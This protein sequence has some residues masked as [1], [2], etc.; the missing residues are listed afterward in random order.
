[1]ESNIYKDCPIYTTENLTLRLTSLKDACELLNCYSDIKAVPL[2]NCDNCHGDDFHYN[3]IELMK[4][5]I[6][7][8]QYSYKNRYFTRLTVISNET[9]EIIGTIEMFKRDAEDEFDLVGV[10]RID[11]QSKYEK[12]QYI[13]EIL[14]IVNQNFYEAFEVD[15]IITKANPT[16]TQRIASLENK[17]YVPVTKKFVYDNY[18]E[19]KNGKN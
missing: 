19:R 2:F 8:W 15:S 6:H 12:Q 3:T 16:S 1:M 5:A 10:L 4:E 11:L 18:F 13:D 7:F 9:K 17:G 14:Q